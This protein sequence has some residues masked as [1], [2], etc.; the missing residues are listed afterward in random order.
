M[1]C[2]SKDSVCA[3]KN[4]GFFVS[5]GDYSFFNE[6]CSNTS[7][8][9]FF[10]YGIFKD[11]IKSHLLEA[12]EKTIVLF[13]MGHSKYQVYYTDLQILNIFLMKSFNTC[14]MFISVVLVKILK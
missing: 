10:E 5:S 14:F 1:A 8:D 2:S 7:Q 3:Y 13:Q 11:A 9:A 12:S 6:M 4:R